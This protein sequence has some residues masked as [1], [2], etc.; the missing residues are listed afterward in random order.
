[1]PWIGQA[2]LGD[3]KEAQMMRKVVAWLGIMSVLAVGVPFPPQVWGHCPETPPEASYGATFFAPITDSSNVPISLEIVADKLTSPLKA[4]SAPGEPNNLYVVDQVGILWQVDLTTG[5]RPKVFLNVR[6]RLVEL[7]VLGSRTFDERGF[8]GVAFHPNYQTNGLLY[9][10]TSEPNAGPPT[11]PTFMPAGIAPDHQN[12]VA[13]WRVQNPGTKNA[14]VI[15]SSRR[16]LMRV[17]WPQFNHDGGDLAFNP[18]AAAGEEDYLYISMGDGGGA[19]DADGQEFIVA[20]GRRRDID[21]PVN[22][23][24]VGHQG[25][26]NAQ[27]LNTPL[28]KILRIDLSGDNSANGQ[29][30]IPAD[31][32]FQGPGQVKEIYAFGFRNPYRFSFDTATGHLY[33]GDVGQ[34]DLE[35]VNL[36]EIGKNYGWNYKEG[37]QFFHING[38]DEGFAVPNPAEGVPGNTPEPGRAAP[39]I[40]PTDPIAQYD[41]HREGHSVIGG[42]VYHGSRIPA[43]TGRYVFGEFSFVFNFPSGPHNYGRLLSIASGPGG[44]R[45]IAEFQDF[46]EAITAIGLS[47]GSNACPL[48]GVAP[49]TLAVLG[50][51]QDANGEV[52]VM[53][54]ING[55]PFGSD[56]VVLRIAP[57]G[58]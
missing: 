12:V 48:S 53:G 39:T 38:N 30:G 6:N 15:P 40:A 18:Q 8:L 10:Y 7:G 47:E 31:N 2:G 19:D 57:A 35:E 14:K 41:L 32:P 27:K 3:N 17:D 22:A 25:D 23:P 21:A 34:N 36:V 4:V 37:T 42:F 24:I 13:E 49:P 1:V 44:L 55:V 26:G 29:Y 58:P 20:T 50:M 45:P 9:T 56:G 28:G 54:N 52:Y 11:L 16:E 51:G 33:V 43:L 5:K 46:D